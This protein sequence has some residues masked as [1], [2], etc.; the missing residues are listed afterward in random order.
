M[1]DISFSLFVN[2]DEERTS[3][4]IR[5]NFDRFVAPDYPEEG[6]EGFYFFISPKVLADRFTLEDN[7]LIKAEKDGELVGAI[8]IRCCSRICLFFVEKDFHNQGIGS[9]YYG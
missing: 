1:K 6:L 3:Q 9:I 2:G 4:F 5:R 7:F 8:A